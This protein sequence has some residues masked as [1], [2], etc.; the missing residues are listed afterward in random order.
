MKIINRVAAILSQAINVV[1]GGMPDET[2]CSRMYRKKLDG[3][4]FGAVACVVLNKLFFWEKDHCKDSYDAELER[5]H[6]PNALK[7]S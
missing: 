5:R 4:K 3:N 7:K 2:L 6:F 1:T